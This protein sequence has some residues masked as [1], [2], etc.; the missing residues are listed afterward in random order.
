MNAQILKFRDIINA[1]ALREY[2]RHHKRLPGSNRTKRLRK[3]Q[4]K[5]VMHWYVKGL[6]DKRERTK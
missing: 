6:C 5:A 2:A 3:K 4:R 1:I